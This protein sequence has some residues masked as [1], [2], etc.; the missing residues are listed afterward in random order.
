MSVVKQKMYSQQRK[1]FS[2]YKRIQQF[3]P[4]STEQNPSV[5]F[6]EITFGT[7]MQTNKR[8]THHERNNGLDI[9]SSLLK[10]RSV[11]KFCCLHL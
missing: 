3:F 6:S 4:E 9:S 1:T 2:G 11:E 8:F 5:G 7:E 10:R